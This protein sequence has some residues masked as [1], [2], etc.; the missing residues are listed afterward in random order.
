MNKMYRAYRVLVKMAV[1][2]AVSLAMQ[3]CTLV[4]EWPLENDV[5]VSANLRI[6]LDV[7]VTKAPL[8]DEAPG[9][10]YDDNELH[11][12]SDNTLMLSDLDF[13]FFDLDGA[14]VTHASGFGNV[15]LS[16]DSYSNKLHR[17][18]AD[19]KVDKIVNN[20]QYR[21]VVVA[22]RMQNQY[23]FTSF[24]VPTTPDPHSPDSRTD[25][26]Y[27]YSQL[28]L[29]TCNPS[30][31]LNS[32]LADYTS[33]NLSGYDYA[34]VP[35][36]GVQK[37]TM[38]IR[39]GEEGTLE[40]SGDIYL[41]RSIAKVKISI[42]SELSRYVKI[43]DS[44]PG[45]ADSGA[46]LSYSRSYG[47]MTP[48]YEN[49]MSCAGATDINTWNS[50]GKDWNGTK[51]IDVNVNTLDQSGSFKA[52]MFKDTDGSCYVYLP[53]QKIGEAYMSVQLQYLDQKLPEPLTVHKIIRFADYNAASVATGKLDIP[54]TEEELEP[55]S[56][57]VMRNHY[58][59]YTITKLDPFELKFEVCPWQ[60]QSTNIDF[61]YVPSQ[62][63]EFLGFSGYDFRYTHVGS[64][65]HFWVKGSVSNPEATITDVYVD[66]NRAVLD[67]G[68][69]A[70]GLCYWKSN[71]VD[72]RYTVRFRGIDYVIIRTETIS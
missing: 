11:E 44:V 22:N 43:M 27:L 59:I 1:A 34:R 60:Y 49:V 41:L 68:E 31:S 5:E 32:H 57:P 20:R 14:F 21:V 29:D 24:A 18:T 33:W 54:L 51:Y 16:L 28:V 7:P 35:M 72:V 23:G 39:V 40:P 52:P 63:E 10:D 25:E 62:I 55:Y 45:N 66:G 13:Y 36:W 9:Y 46:V 50:A 8:G 58:Y 65:L 71:T 12:G 17:Y 67:S 2:T 6:T 4:Y 69:Y 61:G 48:S 30:A 15:S 47:F 37:M 42:G 26:E 70:T 38:K 19:I 64:E 3:C 56:F 53:E